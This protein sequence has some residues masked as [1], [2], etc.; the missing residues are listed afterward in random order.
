MRMIIIYKT[1]YP[2]AAGGA[3][4]AL[5]VLRWETLIEIASEIVVARGA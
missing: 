4:R 2:T 1:D 5:P 3:T